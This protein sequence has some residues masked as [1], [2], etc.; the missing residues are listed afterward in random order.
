MLYERNL[1]QTKANC[2]AARKKRQV[3]GKIK[4]DIKTIK[5]K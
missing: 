3:C 4:K 1:E 5:E 2:S